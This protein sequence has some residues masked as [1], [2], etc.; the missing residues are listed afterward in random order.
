[1]PIIHVAGFA[2]PLEWVVGIIVGFVGL[3]GL[4]VFLVFRGRGE[5][6]KPETGQPT[7]QNL[8]AL[9]PVDQNGNP[10]M[11]KLLANVT[12][13]EHEIVFKEPGVM[14]ESTE[15]EV[16]LRANTA[17][18]MPLPLRDEAGNLVFLWGALKMQGEIILYSFN[19]L[20]KRIRQK[21]DPLEAD[22]QE[23]GRHFIG[24]PPKIGGLPQLLQSTTGK[25][26]L[27]G[28]CVLI[29]F[30]FNFFLVVVTGHWH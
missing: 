6:G 22:V 28:G 30:F 9:N 15:E 10:V 13:T 5:G 19:D 14:S 21:F 16:K 8:V 20:A 4:S 29:G 1:M 23:V 27:I 24:G 25:V 3:I 18:V 12:L 26:I 11:G 2:I 7:E 17:D